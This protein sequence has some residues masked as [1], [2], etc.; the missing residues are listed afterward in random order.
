MVCWRSTQDKLY[1][2]NNTDL[3]LQIPASLRAGVR[4]S[5]NTKDFIPLWILGP[6]LKLN[7]VAFRLLQVELLCYLEM[8]GN[9]NPVR[10]KGE[11][12]RK[13]E[14]WSAFERLNGV[15]NEGWNILAWSIISIS[16]PFSLSPPFSLWCLYLVWDDWKSFEQII[17]FSKSVDRPSLYL[18]VS[19]RPK[20]L[21]FN[22]IFSV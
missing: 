22:L 19:K 12:E 4:P 16:V 9:P 3:W 15:W 11:R 10:S 8:R 18:L 20:I 6:R 5:M 1:I 2:F 13:R 17:Y 7:W 14:V 21:S